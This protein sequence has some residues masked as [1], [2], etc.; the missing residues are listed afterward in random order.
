LNGWIY[1]PID[2]GILHVSQ[3]QRDSTAYWTLGR[4]LSGPFP[5]GRWPLN[6]TASLKDRAEASRLGQRRYL[7]T[8]C[9]SYTYWACYQRFRMGDWV[10]WTVLIGL[11]TEATCHGSTQ[12]PKAKSESF[13][14]GQWPGIIGSTSLAVALRSPWQTVG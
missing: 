4:R 12:D 11:H 3:S 13:G 7:E 14:L 2:E 8:L 10:L 6:H 1:L 5:Q 9:Y